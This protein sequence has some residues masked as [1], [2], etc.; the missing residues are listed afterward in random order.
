LTDL[1]ENSM[2][3]KDWH[4]LKRL[5][6]GE[7]NWGNPHAIDKRIIILLDKVLHQW[8]LDAIV[9]S[10]TNRT[11]SPTSWHYPTSTHLGMALDIVFPKKEKKDIP[12]IFI[13]FMRHKFTGIGLYPGWMVFGE[14]RGGM[15]VDIRPQEYKSL[16]LYDGRTEYAI[17]M[18]T[19]KKFTEG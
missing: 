1:K 19:L 14:N 11:H 4:S 15:H 2:T 18:E 5:N 6:K 3:I 12:N 16:W 7:H 10:G 8:D 17:T 13:N 9:T